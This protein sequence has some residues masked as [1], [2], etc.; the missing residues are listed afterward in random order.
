MSKAQA[1]ALSPQP[2]RQHHRKAPPIVES[3]SPSRGVGLPARY[4]NNKAPAAAYA[5]ASS[6]SLAQSAAP[7]PA[8]RHQSVSVASRNHPN[9]HNHHHFDDALRGSDH[10]P[11]HPPR[12]GEPPLRGPPPLP[13]TNQHAAPTQHRRDHRSESSERVRHRHH[14]RQQRNHSAPYRNHH[15]ST[16]EGPATTTATTTTTML[17]SLKR[18]RPTDD[19]SSFPPHRQE[20]VHTTAAAATT[21]TTTEDH[22]LRR[23]APQPPRWVPPPA[24][25]HR[26]EETLEGP[27][28]GHHHHHH[29]D[30]PR[31]RGRFPDSRPV[32]AHGRTNSRSN[33]TSLL[34]PPVQSEDKSSRHHRDALTVRTTT[35]TAGVG[36]TTPDP[37]AA[38]E[39]EALQVCLRSVS[40]SPKGPDRVPSDDKSPAA[41]AHA[42]SPNTHI[43]FTPPPAGATSPKDPPNE[44]QHP[45][46]STIPPTTHES[47]PSRSPNP[48]PRA[49]VNA[50]PGPG[51]DAVVGVGTRV[52]VYWD[53]EGRYY[54]GTLTERR[55][56]RGDC[57]HIAYDDGDREWVRLDRE[58]YRLAPPRGTNVET[59]EGSTRPRATLPAAVKDPQTCPVGAK[60]THRK[61][62]QPPPPAVADGTSPDTATGAALAS[63]TS[64]SWVE[65]G[66][67][68]RTPG[69]SS[70]SE[71]DEEELVDWAVRMLGAPRPPPL[72]KRKSTGGVSGSQLAWD[73]S[74]GVRGSHVPISEAVKLGHRR[75]RCSST[76]KEDTAS[77]E[78]EVKGKDDAAFANDSE[79]EERSKR[80]KEE[81]RPLS[82]AEVRSILARDMCPAAADAAHWVRRSMRQPSRSALESP[83]VKALLEKLRSNDTDMVVLK[84]KKYVNDPNA[85]QLVLDAVLDALEE[86]T[87]CESLY[88]QVRN[89]HIMPMLLPPLV[90]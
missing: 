14:H 6:S 87:N 19:D 35:L 53:G 49:A 16:E 34:P 8:V 78:S 39:R 64:L 69:E 30:Q 18:R 66:L 55:G 77:A 40:S 51:D 57:F 88:I 23:P 33:G 85:P 62:R 25:K 47:I 10:H 90:C 67:P 2:Q 68:A 76:C 63:K 9:H 37:D 59:I 15:H 58:V 7:T 48:A 80:R 24:T 20:G 61:S 3:S 44:Q 21:T 22:S 54:A 84:M 65:A 42:S 4:N 17:S 45:L 38:L 70:D 12:S 83:Q 27:T 79:L 71:T 41:E 13:C 52:E 29:D 73:T 89:I 11:R 72:A 28:H 46:P 86:N 56:T 26:R 43:G 50:P 74:W 36:A 60:T 75:R 82:Q 31:R 32:Q 81:A 5:T 1:L